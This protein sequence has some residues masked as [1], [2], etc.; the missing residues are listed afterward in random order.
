MPRVISCCWT[1]RCR[2]AANSVGGAAF[3]L[4]PV[5][6]TAARISHCQTRRIRQNSA[7]CLSFRAKPRCP[8]RTEESLN[9][10][11]EER[12]TLEERATMADI[13]R[14]RHSASHVL[15]FCHVERSRDISY[16]FP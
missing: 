15:A 3:W 12:K 8:A 7:H 4:Q 1:I 13:E 9:T 10:K 5:A 6:A 2:S 11:S 14:R 16:H